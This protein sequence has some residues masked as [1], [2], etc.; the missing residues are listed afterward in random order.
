MSE[1]ASEQRGDGGRGAASSMFLSI[2]PYKKRGKATCS[3]LNPINQK[4]ED[5]TLAFGGRGERC[6]EPEHRRDPGACSRSRAA[7]ISIANERSLSQ[8]VLRQH[9]RGPRSDKRPFSA[10]PSLSARRRRS[11]DERRSANTV[12]A[13]TAVEGSAPLCSAFKNTC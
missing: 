9:S 2:S 5:R 8:C 1:Q 13:N 3:K 4:G 7:Q 12:L 10:P 11:V 6:R